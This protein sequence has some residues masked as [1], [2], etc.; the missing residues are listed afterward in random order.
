MGG[1][2]GKTKNPGWGGGGN[3]GTRDK[4]ESSGAV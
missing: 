3:M 1:G 4:F 2:G